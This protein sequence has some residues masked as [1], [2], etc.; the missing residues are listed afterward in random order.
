[1]LVALGAARIDCEDVGE[2]CSS[3]S[4]PCVGALDIAQVY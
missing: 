1:V 3:K 4:S 2:L